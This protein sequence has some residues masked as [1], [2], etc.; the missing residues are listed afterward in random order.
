M[1]F[2]PQAS[3][4]L[5]TTSAE[6][7]QPPQSKPLIDQVE[8]VHACVALTSF[9]SPLAQRNSPSRNSPLSAL[10]D[11]SE[12]SA[13]ATRALVSTAEASAR[14]NTLEACHVNMLPE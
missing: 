5:Y 3:P 7:V 10:S 2:L 8:L 12:V 4:P 1:K 14:L 13:K 11:Y 9:S 6:Q